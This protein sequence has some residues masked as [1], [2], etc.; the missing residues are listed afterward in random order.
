MRT[1][2]CFRFPAASMSRPTSSRL[3]TV[4][5]RRPLFGIRQV[6]P[7]LVTFQCP[8]EEEA[9]RSN[10]SDYCAD[11]K[12]ALLQQIRLVTAKFVW[13]EL[14]RRLS[15]VLREVCHSTEIP[16]GCTIGIITTLQFLQHHLA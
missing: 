5:T 13:S 10:T 9:Q 6:L 12:L 2:R 1:A 14:I 8:D 4:G 16:A 11:G 15:E 7:E 3:N